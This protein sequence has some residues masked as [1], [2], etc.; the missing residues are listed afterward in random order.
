[1]RI[2]LITH[3]YLPE[4]TPPQRRWTAFAEAFRRRGWDVDIVAPPGDPAHIPGADAYHGGRLMDRADVGVGPWGERVVHT[5]RIALLGA[6]REGRFLGS[7]VHAVVAIPR[8]FL[9]ER[10]DVLVV[11][12][13][14]LPTVVA[15]WVLSRCRRVPLIVE[16]RD[17]WPDLAREAEVSIG[18]LSRLMDRLVTGTQRSADL[19]VTVTEGFA[20]RLAQRGIG[21]VAV[22]SNGVPLDEI[23]PA[24]VRH[25]PPR[26]LHVLYVGN[27][28]ESQGLETTIRAAALLQNGTER[29]TVRLVGSGTRK[30]ELWALNESLGRP[31]EMLDSVHG[32][33]LRSQYD[34]ADTCLVTLRPDWPSFAWTV[35]SKTY[36]L[37]AVGK[38]I[39]GVVTGEAAQILSDSGAADLVDH[40]A[41]ALAAL[42]TR[43][44]RDPASTTTDGRG[45]DWVTDRANLPVL[46]QRFVDL[47]AEVAGARWESGAPDRGRARQLVANLSLTWV[48]VWEHVRD[49]PAV[50]ALQITRRLPPAVRR[51]VAGAAA[52]LDSGPLQV[53]GALGLAAAGRDEELRSRAAAAAERGEGN[54]ILLRYA[55]TLIGTGDV[56]A[57]RE[58]L[59]RARPGSAGH[60]SVTARLAWHEGHLSE[61]IGVLPRAGRGSRQRA[62]FVSERNRITTT[63]PRLDPVPGYVP[64]ERSVLH[65]LDNSLPHTGAGYAQRSHSIL[66]SLR[67]EGW[68]VAAVTRLGWPVQ[69][70][71]VHAAVQDTVEGIDYHRLLPSRPASGLDQRLQ[72]H[73]ELLLRLVLRLRPELLHT[74]T[75]FTNGLVVRAVAE[76]VGIPWVYEVRGQRADSWASTR[77]PESGGSEY[78]RAFTARESE[79]ARAADAVVTLGRGMRENLVAQGVAADGIV[80]S[81]NAIGGSFLAD[82]MSRTEAR[83]RLGLESDLEYVGSVSSIVPYEGLD[84]LVRAVAALAPSRPRLRLLL[85]GD[86]T[87]LPGVLDLADVLGIKDRVI[88]TGRVDRSLAPTYHQALDVFVVPRRDIEVTR[89]VTPM[90]SVEASASARPVVASDLPALA[91]LVQDGRTGMLVPAEDPAALA[92]ALRQL[93]EDPELARTMGRAGRNWALG[94][95]TWQANGRRY[96]QLYRS[97]LHSSAHPASSAPGP[98]DRA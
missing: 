62:R 64:H 67:D 86:G 50:M 39:T 10:P 79:T 21:P 87:A 81:P 24:A 83:S 14:A 60:R 1:M 54:G 45:R 69:V 52:R 78:Y 23:E 66:M 71:V 18:L 96:T 36:E 94:E 92:A 29:I 26:E 9:V 34:W 6:T 13:P 12:V 76:A 74:T 58:I 63:R 77:G 3:S 89:A 48:T 61:A 42:W 47:A 30:D 85:V 27:H 38:H 73:A 80:L 59:D 82:P 28:G 49:D 22:V 98:A 84:V 33:G 11:T 41:E 5:L 7:I 95:R 75:D 15:G 40:D 91:E 16:M 44:A 37:L 43:L 46:G 68:D 20:E 35:P 31:V 55:D 56:P 70:G 72:Q 32:P 2:Q 93:L 8:T 17:A 57:A 65:V 25:R 97:L 88:A 53:V 51:A 4:R 90:K 19:V